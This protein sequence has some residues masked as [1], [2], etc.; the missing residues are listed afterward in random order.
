MSQMDQNGLNF[1]WKKKAYFTCCT[2]ER[3]SAKSA[4]SCEICEETEKVWNV[5][6]FVKKCEKCGI[7][8]KVRNVRKSWKLTKFHQYFI[9]FHKGFCI[10]SIS[11]GFPENYVNLEEFYENLGSS[12]IFCEN[13]ILFANL[14]Q[15]HNF[16][17]FMSKTSMCKIPYKIQWNIDEI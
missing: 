12:Y 1:H 7:Y 3:K 11:C 10:W 9:G 14:C 6:D 4:K 2:L 15:N 17:F 16:L 5:R 8:A 13:H